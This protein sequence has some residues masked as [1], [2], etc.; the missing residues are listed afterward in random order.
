MAVA[1]LRLSNGLDLSINANASNTPPNELTTPCSS[2]TNFRQLEHGGNSRRELLHSNSNGAAANIMHAD[3]YL[4]IYKPA[5]QNSNCNI[6]FVPYWLVMKQ[7]DR[8]IMKFL[9]L[10]K[11]ATEAATNVDDKP[12]YTCTP[13]IDKPTETTVPTEL[14]SQLGIFHST[15]HSSNIDVWWLYDDG[16]LTILI[17]YI[18]SLRSQ[19]SRCKIRIFALT[20]HQMELEVEERK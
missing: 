10:A 20:N 18:L 11:I 15:Q 14:L 3:S 13:R 19:F 9:I 1:I 4:N 5:P 16:G 6:T 12:T 2:V 8:I 7:K 17:P